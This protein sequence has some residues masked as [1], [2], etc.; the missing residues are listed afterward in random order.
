M[1]DTGDIDMTGLT[2]SRTV[3][4]QCEN[5][6]VHIQPCA[7]KNIDGEYGRMSLILLHRANKDNNLILINSGI[8][9][10]FDSNHL[11]SSDKK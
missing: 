1:G 11:K 8:L 7:K 3:M 5:L 9:R 4:Y 2:L 6:P 10:Y